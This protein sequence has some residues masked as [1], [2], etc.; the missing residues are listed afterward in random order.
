MGSSYSQ[1]LSELARV[2]NPE[3]LDP[4][5]LEPDPLEQEPLDPESDTESSEGILSWLW[6]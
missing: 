3:P 2:S 5:P 1:H 4:E 6:F